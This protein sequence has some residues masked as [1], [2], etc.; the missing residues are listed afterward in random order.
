MGQKVSAFGGYIVTNFGSANF[1]QHNSQW[2]YDLEYILD[3]V[4]TSG[5]PGFTEGLPILA[6]FISATFSTPEDS[7]LYPEAIGF[8]PGTVIPSL[9]FKRGA[10]AIFDLLQNGVVQSYKPMNDQK[11]ARVIE[12]TLKYG[13]LT[14]NAGIP[15]L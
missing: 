14:L 8:I 13:V 9:W 12:I 10:S 4:T 7:T 11:K 6:D 3:D 5:S 1:V 2:S 15:A